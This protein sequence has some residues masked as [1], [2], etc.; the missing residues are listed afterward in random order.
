M[1]YLFSCD[2]NG[3][4]SIADILGNKNLTR[5]VVTKYEDYNNHIRS[6][7]TKVTKNDTIIL[8]TIDALA[9]TTRADIRLGTSD[10]TE[11]LWL[12]RA[13]LGNNGKFSSVYLDTNTMIMRH[14]KNVNRSGEGAK[15]IV[16]V[17]E[18]ERI[19][20]T[21]V[22]PTKKRAPD[23]NAEFLGSL[24]GSSSDVFRLSRVVDD[25]LD[26][27]GAVLLAADSRILQL[28]ETDEYVAKFQVPMEKRPSIK[29]ALANPTYQS[30]CEHLGKIPTWLTIYGPSGAGKSTF[31]TSMLKN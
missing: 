24:M 7:M 10:P 18:A 12:Q 21:T 16:T 26:D 14:L 3:S 6:I 13:K 1:N 31:A 19:D 28:R 22:P 23:L 29:R 15:I 4:D 8:D 17:H 27:N 30:L 20:E 25:I 2:G 5:I 11:D 9:S